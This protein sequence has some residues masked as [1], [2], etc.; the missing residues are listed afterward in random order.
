MQG[1]VCPGTCTGSG[2]LSTR[3]T[4]PAGS[5][6]RD[7]YYN[8]NM[9][10]N[11]FPPY[12]LYGIRVNLAVIIPVF[13]EAE[14]IASLLNEI[15]AALEDRLEYEI[16]VVDDGSTDDTPA[17]LSAR[18]THCPRLKIIRHQLRCGQTAALT[19]GVAAARAIWIATLDGDGQNDPADILRLYQ[20]MVQAP[21]TVWLVAGYR[22]QRRDSLS[23]RFAA[24]IASGVR[25]VVLGDRTPDSGCGL[26]VMA[27]EV[28]GRLPQF[29]HMHRFLPAL[30]QRQGGRVI[31]VEVHH[32]ARKNG[33]SKYGIHDRLWIGIVDLLG[34][35][36]LQRRSKQPRIVRED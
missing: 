16:I 9:P 18:R 4:A 6:N 32:R 30:V 5:L 21:D 8:E 33:Q 27:R 35:L 34:V 15:T 36:W 12:I 22:K 14:N 31:S 17:V 13:N 19:T 1:Y 3:W 29:D 11:Q 20:V 24:R 25:Y 10:E 23:K 7:S 26:K 28:F 2:V